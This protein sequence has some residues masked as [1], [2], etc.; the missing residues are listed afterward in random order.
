M[1]RRSF[2]NLLMIKNKF[3]NGIYIYVKVIDIVIFVD[4]KKASDVRKFY[5]NMD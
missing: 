2:W 5:R 3:K 1:S 4:F